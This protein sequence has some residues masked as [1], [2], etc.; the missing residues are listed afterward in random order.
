MR[1][2]PRLPLARAFVRAVRNSDYNLVKLAAL[3]GFA[4]NTQLSDHLNSRRVPVTALNRGRFQTLAEIVGY[5]GPVFDEVSR[6]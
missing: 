2:I 4:A 6:G 3:S 1:P 5:D